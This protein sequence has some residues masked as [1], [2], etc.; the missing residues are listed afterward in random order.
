MRI[1]H[2][3]MVLRKIVGKYACMR[4]WNVEE[5][6]DYIIKSIENFEKRKRIKRKIFG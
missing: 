4:G 5:S 2:E 3:R 6:V 1:T